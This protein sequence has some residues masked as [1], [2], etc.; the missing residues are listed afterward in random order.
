MTPLILA[1]GNRGKLR[2]FQEF[3]ASLPTPSGWQ[4]QLKPADVE[5]EETG[6]TFREN[7]ELK[8]RGVA[9][10]TGSWALADDS[11]LAVVALKGAPGVYSA[12]YAP[13]DGERIA[14]VLSELAAIETQQGSINRHAMFA[15]AI[16]LSNPAGEIM[17]LAEGRCRGEILPA[18][19]GEAGFGYDPIFWDPHLGLTFAEMS[20]EQ[21]RQVSHRG[22]ALAALR[23]Q[24]V[25]L[26]ESCSPCQ[27]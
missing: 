14:R 5:I 11:G 8:A 13:S 27:D 3:F 6:K 24:L 7:A 2:E 1:S 20:V 19:R 10:A 21:K 15:C 18:P 17:A 22:R 23:E 25:T 12:R 26:G 9:L 4:L 16:A